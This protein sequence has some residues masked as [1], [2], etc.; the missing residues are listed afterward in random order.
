MDGFTYTMTVSRDGFEASIMNMNGLD[1][2]ASGFVPW[3]DAGTTYE[4][5]F[6]R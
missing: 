1:F 2:D 5:L 3:A 6:P 4:A